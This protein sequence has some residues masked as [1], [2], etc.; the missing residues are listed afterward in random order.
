MV[1]GDSMHN[2]YQRSVGNAKL[3]VQ[4]LLERS[5]HS[6]PDLV[7]NISC[8]SFPESVHVSKQIIPGGIQRVSP[9][10]SLG[11]VN[12]PGHSAADCNRPFDD[13]SGNDAL[14]YTRKCTR[15]FATQV[16]LVCSYS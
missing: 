11:F 12:Q 14:I 8:V 1:V 2:R 9:V 13:H 5:R 4:A 7:R 6:G 3:I 10:V 16:K 15:I